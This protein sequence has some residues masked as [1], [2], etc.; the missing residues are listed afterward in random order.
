MALLIYYL[1]EVSMPCVES[2]WERHRLKLPIGNYEVVVF[3]LLVDYLVKYSSH[4]RSLFGAN[5]G[6]RH[7]LGG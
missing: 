6:K 7:Y 1:S 5:I 4:T 2:D 3:T